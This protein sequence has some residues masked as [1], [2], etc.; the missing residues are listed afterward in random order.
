MGVGLV[1][2]ALTSAAARSLPPQRFATGMAMSLTSRQLGIVLGIAVVVAVIGTPA[3]VTRSTRTAPASDCALWSGWRPAWSRSA[4]APR[5][6]P[7]SPRAPSRGG[8]VMTP[9]VWYRALRPDDG[10]LLDQIM[11][12]MSP[13]SRYQRYHGPKPRLTSG[14][15]RYL[16]SVDERDH[17]AIVALAPEGDPVAVVRAVRLTERPA[18]RRARDRGRRRLA[19]PGVGGALI[20]R[21][22]RRAAGVGSNGS[23]RACSTRRLRAQPAAARLARGRAGWA[24]RDPGCRCVGAG[25]RGRPAVVPRGAPVR[26]AVNC[27]WV[28]SGSER[29]VTPP[30]CLV[31]PYDPQGRMVQ[32]KRPDPLPQCPPFAARPR[33]LLGREL[34]D[35]LLQPRR[36]TGEVL[37]RG[38]DLLGRRAGLLRRG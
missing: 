12:G 1:L 4:S 3:P 13:Q 16:T 9:F 33:P 17:L 37:G 26:A 18:R 38:G 15:R 31:G 2:P 23:S 11:D 28:G 5:R 36:L 25:P 32:R 34:A 6:V 22:A 19:E 14:D 7:P 29:G 35:E 21:I 30:S 20:A 27:G 8:R 10:E 24:E